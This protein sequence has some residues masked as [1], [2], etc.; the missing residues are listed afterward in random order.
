MKAGDKLRFNIILSQVPEFEQVTAKWRSG[1]ITA[2]EAMR[3][4]HMSKT[5]FYRKV[6][7]R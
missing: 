7:R 5:T 3:M 1:A 6:K 2:A 4:L